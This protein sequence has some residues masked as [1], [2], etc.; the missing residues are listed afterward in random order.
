MSINQGY[1][2]TYPG[3][4]QGLRPYPYP[5]PDPGQSVIQILIDVKIQ[6]QACVYQDK[7]QVKFWPKKNRFQTGLNQTET[8]FLSDQRHSRIFEAFFAVIGFK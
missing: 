5:D 4:H 1:Q 6:I 8:E 2:I 3:Q 7:I